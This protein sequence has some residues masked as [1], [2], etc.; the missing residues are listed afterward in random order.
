MK[1]SKLKVYD[2]EESI[3]A[4]KYPMSDSTE[5]CTSEITKRTS[6]LG[7]ADGCSGHDCML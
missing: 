7:H 3:Q 5:D 1:I 2:I 6:A 4:S